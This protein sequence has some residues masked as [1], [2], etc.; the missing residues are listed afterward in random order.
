MP[1]LIL[2]RHGQASFGAEDYDQLSELGFRQAGIVAEAL[3]ERRV[4]PTTVACGD[5]LRQRQTAAPFSERSGATVTVDPRWNEYRSDDLLAVHSI[6]DARLDG[7]Q[8]VSTRTFQALLEGGLRNWADAGDATTAEESWPAFR[9]RVDAAVLDAVGALGSGETA[10][11]FTSAGTIAA[12]CT[13]LLGGTF[14]TFI[15]LNRV[16]VNTAATTIVSGASG[17]T[18]LSF[19]DHAHLQHEDGLITFR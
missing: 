11:A 16:A 15:Q 9:A 13:T 1:A 12:A 8:T 2:V 4:A 3:S 5:L 6:S 17:R 18:V 19:N 14:E 7:P 10:V